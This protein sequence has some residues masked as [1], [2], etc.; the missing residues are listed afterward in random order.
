MNPSS[1]LN[2][3][4]RDARRGIHGISTMFLRGEPAVGKTFFAESVCKVWRA[5]IQRF[6][7]LYTNVEKEKLLLDINLPNLIMSMTPD[8]SEIVET[9]N[10]AILFFQDYLLSKYGD[11]NINIEKIK[12]PEIT[13][14]KKIKPEDIIQDGILYQILKD[15]HKG[16]VVG[17]FDEWDKADE[18]IDTLMYDY[19]QN[20]RLTDPSHADLVG[21]S[22][23]ILIIFTSNEQ[24]QPALPFLRRVRN[25][26]I[27]YP[28]PVEQ[29]DILKFRCPEDIQDIGE[30]PIKNLISLSNAYR[31]T[32]PIIRSN[33]YSLYR[34]VNDLGAFVDLPEAKIKDDVIY[35]IKAW[36]SH[37]KEDVKKM[38]TLKID[39][40]SFDDYV[41][42][43]IVKKLK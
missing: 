24:R 23:N 18:E 42:K 5:E 19:L 12:L 29:L 20:C 8:L 32:N 26:K 7:Q 40:I 30:T 4:I 22:K 11:S 33:T 28:T 1:I 21:I 38:D 3:A 35:D 14:K 31:A 41:V 6:F 25:V 39:N 27:D 10:K 9:F 34:I 13:T 2:L 17:V 36:F 43:N 37:E 16:R 15:S